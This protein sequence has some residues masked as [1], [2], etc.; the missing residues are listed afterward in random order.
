[1]WFAYADIL[2]VGRMLPDLMTTRQANRRAQS[3]ETDAGPGV[4]GGR[5]S[6]TEPQPARSYRSDGVA[7]G[8]AWEIPALAVDEA[9]LARF[10]QLRA[11]EAR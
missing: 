11:V 6:T 2:Q 9:Q 5:E 1:V 10:W 4:E 3:N 8:V 7:A